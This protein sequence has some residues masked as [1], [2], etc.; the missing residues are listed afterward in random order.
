MRDGSHRT[1]SEGLQLLQ[2][3]LLSGKDLTKKSIT[4][5]D[6]HRDV[7]RGSLG[8]ERVLPLLPM[9]GR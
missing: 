5:I 6:I 3:V 1:E 8:P 4:L 7:L 9:L 2:E